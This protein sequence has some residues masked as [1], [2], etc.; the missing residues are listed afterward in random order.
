MRLKGRRWLGWC[1]PAL[2]LSLSLAFVGGNLKPSR[3]L[4]A[5][6]W[7]DDSPPPP[8]PRP[9]RERK[10]TD[11]EKQADAIV[12]AVGFCAVL[13]AKRSCHATIIALCSGSKAVFARPFVRLLALP[14]S[15]SLSLSPSFLSLLLSFLSLLL[16]PSLSLPP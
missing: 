14:L 12:H 13:A 8:P 6:A 5:Q 10:M 16:S 7:N 9:P 11:V 2:G 1:L 15:L 4:C 3:R